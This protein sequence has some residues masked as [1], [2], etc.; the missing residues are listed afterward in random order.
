MSDQDPIKTPIEVQTEL[1][2]GIETASTAGTIVAVGA[3]ASGVALAPFAPIAGIAISAVGAT[4]GA[5]F[6]W[7][8]LS[9]ESQLQESQP[10]PTAHQQV[11]S[12]PPDVR[13]S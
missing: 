6:L 12:S 10:P 7:Q 4:I 2:R 13:S 9:G 11:I 1:K 5:Y 8:K 3:I